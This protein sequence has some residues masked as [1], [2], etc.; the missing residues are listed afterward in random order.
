MIPSNNNPKVHEI[1][2]NIII[3]T[4]CKNIKA[5]I[6]CVKRYDTSPSNRR[7]NKKQITNMENTGSNNICKNITNT[8]DDIFKV[9]GMCYKF[10]KLCYELKYINEFGL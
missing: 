5:S 4:P 7:N 8:F 9:A 1:T 2:L 10:T 6:V 3:Y